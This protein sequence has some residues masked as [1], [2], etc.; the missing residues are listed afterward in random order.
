MKIAQVVLMYGMLSTLIAM[1]KGLTVDEMLASVSQEI[2]RLQKEYEESN[3]DTRTRKVLKKESKEYKSTLN[4]LYE[5]KKKGNEYTY[6]P[7]N[8]SITETNDEQQQLSLLYNL[9]V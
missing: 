1:E 9:C 4:F 6:F 7:I 8:L 5:S 2:E 3:G